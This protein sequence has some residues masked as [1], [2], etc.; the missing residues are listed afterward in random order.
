MDEYF[1]DLGFDGKKLIQQ[2]NGC[3]FSQDSV[4]LSNSAI[5]KKGDRVLDLGAGNGIVSVLV[6]LKKPYCEITAI[7]IQRAQAILA[8]KN[9][10]LNSLDTRVRVVCGD[11]ANIAEYVKAGSF[12][13]VLC[14]PPYFADIN[15]HNAVDLSDGTHSNPAAETLDTALSAGNT[16]PFVA[17]ITKSTAQTIPSTNSTAANLEIANTAPTAENENYYLKSNSVRAVSRCE[18]SGDLRQF[19]SAAAYALKFGGDLYIIYKADRMC[20]LTEVLRSCSLEP[21][22]ALFICPKLSKGADTVLIRARKGAKPSMTN[23]I[24]VV[25]NEDGSYTEAFKR[26][27]TA[28]AAIDTKTDNRR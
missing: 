27:Y 2:K 6:G 18:I 8:E 10:R 20:D 28:P 24:L 26:L 16:A 1:V 5:I 9:A 14:N 25:M 3:G 11:I 21:K 4:V 12:D 22:H 15:P 7:E 23:E 13:K 17:A 19:V